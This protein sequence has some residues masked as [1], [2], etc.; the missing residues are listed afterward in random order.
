MPRVFDADKR[1][2]L[3]H[4]VQ[5]PKSKFF[6]T[7]VGQP[8]MWNERRTHQLW[9]RVLKDLKVKLVVDM[10][11]SSGQLARASLE[12]ATCC[13]AMARNMEHCSWLQNVIDRYATLSV[14]KTGSFLYEAD[15]AAQ[16]KEMFQDVLDQLNEQDALEGPE[17]VDGDW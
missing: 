6:D 12:T 9:S 8:L 1:A 10:S 4:A 2:I 14:A 15:L 16:V 7:S 13:I 17:L 11:P 3:G 5:Q